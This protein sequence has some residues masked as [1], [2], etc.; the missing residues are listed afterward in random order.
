MSWNDPTFPWLSPVR[1]ALREIVAIRRALEQLEAQL[2]GTARLEG[3]S[4]TDLAEDLA[5][6]RQGARQ[7]HLAN[8]PLPE[9]R[10]RASAAHRRTGGAGSRLER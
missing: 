2:V 4:W 10:A 9:Q 3:W 8:D 1:L 7:R 6:T 5:L